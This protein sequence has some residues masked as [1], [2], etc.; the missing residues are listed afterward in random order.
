MT[1][2]PVD[3]SE[4]LWAGLS[5][6]EPPNEPLRPVWDEPVPITARPALPAFPVA[7]LPAWLGDMVRGVA[8][9]TQTPVDLA[10][11]LALAVIATAA[12]G[13]A[14]V[15]IRGHWREPVNLYTAIALD[16]GN[17]KSAVFDLMVRPL[18]DAERTL[19][20]LSGPVRAE[21]E[22]TIRLAKTA[23]DKAA[24][25][26]ASAEPSTR[27]ALTAEAVALAQEV[28]EMT[29]PA[30]PQLIADDATPETIGTL[31]A[32]QDGRISCLSAEGE[33]FDI[34]A[35]RY[36]GRPNMG[37]FLKGHAGD[38][39]RVNRQGRDSEHI[40]SPAVTIGLAIQ[41]EVLDSLARIDGADG[42]GLL[43]RFLYSKPLSL[44]GSRNLSPTL[45]S[46]DTTAHY[47]RKLGGLTLALAGWTD[48]AVLT[49]TPEAD[50]VI[51]AF[52]K[53]TESRLGKGGSFAPIV[54]WASKRDGAVARIA[55]LL[56]LATH[57][58]DGWQRP[59]EAVTMAAATELGDYFTAHALDVFDAMTAAPARDAAY[60]VLT[61][62]SASR[63][64][65][66]SKRELFR[67]L[68]R[69]DFPAIG[70]LDPALALLEEHGWIRQQPQPPRAGRGGRP[71]SPRY[72]THPRLTRGGA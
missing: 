53:V 57:P 11:C 38:M 36:S 8:E 7:T 18:L 49:L 27:D 25:K 63:M 5:S 21:A 71:P 24:Q 16:P 37:M 6:L 41:P 28:E 22:T 68:P 43:A 64:D 4:D 13:R 32:Q 12:G 26:A 9:E 58:E 10:G 48:P 65:G 42:R 30:V 59:I 20:E 45:L 55:G 3:G 2:Q 61:H 23:A 44:V 17:R 31:L 54:K 39:V 29:V 19:I 34:I 46:E 47:A 40:D 56:H 14:K 35:G 15:C 62:L 1:A 33:L 51:L 50:A 66:F 60:T 67:A 69:A 52:Q 70:D 72:D